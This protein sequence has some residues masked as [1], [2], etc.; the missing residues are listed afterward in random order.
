MSASKKRKTNST[1]SSSKK[2]VLMI[3]GDFSE[4]LE[5]FFA[6]QALQL[7]GFEVHTVC[8]GKK[9]GEKIA[10]SVH[11][12][13]GFQ[14][15][16]EKRGH[17]FP[18]TKDFKDVKPQDYSGL[19]LPGGRGSEYLRLDEKVISVTKYF[20]D[21][22]IPIAAL[23]HGPQILATAGVCK[24]R[25]M[26]CY[27][28]VRPELQQCGADYQDIQDSNCVIDGNLI[29]GVNWNSN[30]PVIKAFAEKMGATIKID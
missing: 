16:S 22:N 9:D 15:Y 14:T 10:T 11:D 8:P 7:I 29:T 28:A 2:R 3:V 23:C 30:A 18:I 21:H 26:T 20:S 1:S 25:K 6:F 19:Y 27:Q 4:D 24:G 13:D 12:F 17:N 5:C